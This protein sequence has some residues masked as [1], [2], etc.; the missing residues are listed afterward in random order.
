[1]TAEDVRNDVLLRPLTTLP[2][3]DVETADA[4]R[5]RRRCHAALRRNQSGLLRPLGPV[6]AAL[7]AVYL[8]E[9]VWRALSLLG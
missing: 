8:L 1:M 2:I 4:E 5:I 9:V 7:S 6:A 3:D